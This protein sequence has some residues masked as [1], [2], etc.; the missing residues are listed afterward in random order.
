M[1]KLSILRIRSS[2]DSITKLVSVTDAPTN[3]LMQQPVHAR[4]HPAVSWSVHPPP[5]APSTITPHFSLLWPNTH[6]NLPYYYLCTTY[7]P[8]YVLPT[9]YLC[10][11]YLLILIHSDSDKHLDGCTLQA[12]GKA[13]RLPTIARTCKSKH[14]DV[15]LRQTSSW[16]RLRSCTVMLSS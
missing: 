10:T 7:V 2:S 8:T 9:Y 13:D 12:S 3:Q 6:T 15:G 5:T 1:V 11:T 16:S 4:E 14:S